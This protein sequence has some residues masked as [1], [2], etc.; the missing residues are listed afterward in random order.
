MARDDRDLHVG[1]QRRLP[2]FDYSDP[3]AV[4][5]ITMCTADR[6]PA[7]RDPQLAQVVLD[8]LDWRRYHQG[9]AVYAYC[10]MPDHLHLLLRAGRAGSVGDVIKGI[11]VFTTIESWTLGYQGQLWQ[12]RFYDHVLRRAEDARQIAEYIRQNPVRTGL[13]EDPEAY[14][15]SGFLDPLGL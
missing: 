3:D 15:Y 1:A 11:K 4:Y 9:I 5:S 7:F 13:V 10:L 2:G 12:D 8:A 6:R 14:P